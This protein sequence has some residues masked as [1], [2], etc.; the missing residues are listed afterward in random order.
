MRIFIVGPSRCGKSAAAQFLAEAL[1]V[2][3][4]ETGRIVIRELAK[5]YGSKADEDRWAQMISVC[6]REY[7]EELTGLG[8]LMTRLKPD[9]L[10]HACADLAPIVVGVRR[11]CEV[12][13]Y[14]HGSHRARWN[15]IWIKVRGGSGTERDDHF[16]LHDQP[17]N[18]EVRN[19]GTLNDLRSTMQEIGRLIVTPAV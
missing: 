3:Y 19:F 12:M 16:E 10:I 4:A 6:K 15:S 2:H 11:R 13:G 9:C 1:G 18:F 5:L 8:D 17:A 14:L 7:R